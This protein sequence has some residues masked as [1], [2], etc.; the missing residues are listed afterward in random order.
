MSGPKRGDSSDEDD[1]ARVPELPTE[2]TRTLRPS[3]ATPRPAG[4]TDV[5]SNATEASRG[6]EGKA[7]SAVVQ[8]VV[9]DGDNTTRLSLRGREVLRLDGERIEIVRY[10]FSD[11]DGPRLEWHV[12]RVEWSEGLSQPYELTL[13]LVTDDLSVNCD[14]LLGAQGA[15]EMARGELLRTAYGIVQRVDYLGVVADRQ[16]VR[17]SV[18]PAFGLLV[19]QI[20]SRIFQDM[21]AVEIVKAVLGP[22]L[23]GYGRELDASSKVKGKYDTRDYCVQYRESNFA[24]A[25]R[26]LEE[27]GIAYY[28][29][30]DDDGRKEK[31]VLCDNNNDYDDV[32][33]VVDDEVPIIPDRPELADRES[34]RGFEWCQREQVNQVV[35]RGFNWKTPPSPDEGTKA[36]TDAQHHRVRELYE[37]DDR[38]QIVDAGGN[39]GFTGLAQREPMA[40]RRLELFTAGTA[41]G[42]GRSNVTGFMPGRKLRLG[43]HVRPELDGGRFLLT[44]VVHVGNAPDETRLGEDSELPRYENEVECLP[45]AHAFRPPL[46]TA[47]PRVHG[48]ETA[49]VVGPGGEE[50]HTDKWG[51]IKIQFH[52]DRL[53]PADG[54][55]SCWVR[56]GQPW[57]GPGWGT[58]FLP[59]IGMEVIVD[60]LEG[61]PDRPLVVGCVYNGT[62]T[63]YGSP[64]GKTKTGLKSNSS[65]G[66]GGS[67]ELSFDDAAG[68][69][70]IF[71]H[72][73]KDYTEVIEN[74]HTTTV[75]NNQTI[76]VDVDQ[77]VTVT[78]NQT[79][80]ITGNQTQSITGDQT[81]SVSG[82]QTMSVTKDRTVTIDGSQTVTIKGGLSKLDI[83]G[84]YKVDASN[85]IE[86]QA[87]THFKLTVGGSSIMVEPGKITI[88][89]GGQAMLVL[90]VDALMASSKGSQVKL[91]ANALTA[92]STGGLVELTADAIMQA[93]GGGQVKLTG[94]AELYGTKTIVAGEVAGLELTADAS[95]S[96]TNVSISGDAKVGIAGGAVSS[97]AS[98]SNEISGSV[99]KIN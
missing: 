44:R 95:L 21:T 62:N 54:T 71:A 3:G 72:A 55:S 84:D 76:T 40:T 9:R 37:H 19:Q 63:P 77:T 17:V 78:G 36:R 18:V 5:L 79:Q 67:N 81:E 45:F 88:S 91:D 16:L 69:E 85:T 80:S 82:A 52:W 26:L 1:P 39:E 28:F 10:G 48:P 98:G 75:H 51:R 61:N 4:E 2:A 30:P 97:A 31:L 89:A 15:F 56:V 25:C 8:S 35:M 60:F 59:R 96:G 20:D 64:E 92:A 58:W 87:P 24:F 53:Q 32:P 38:R 66:G 41:H 12:R 14:E 13:E 90:D 33:L 22:A 46:V 27:E 93:S 86:I 6:R 99:V 49:T 50:I 74:D 43:P 94:D 83:T 23:A 70:A 68:S 42:R 57:A 11:L 73:Q 29:E 7:L 65:P 34:L 47:K